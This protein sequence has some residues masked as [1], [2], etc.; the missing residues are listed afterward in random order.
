MAHIDRKGGKRMK[1]NHSLKG[2]TPYP[3]KD[4]I[5]SPGGIIIV[6]MGLGVVAAIQYSTIPY[7]GLA[8]STAGFIF[9][10]IAFVTYYHRVN[11]RR[12]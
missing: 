8:G 7:S 11:K 9:M 6:L 12:W 4:L 1:S 5:I 3:L 2:R 10:V